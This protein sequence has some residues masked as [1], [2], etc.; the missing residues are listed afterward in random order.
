MVDQQA[1]PQLQRVLAQARKGVIKS[2][3]NDGVPVFVSVS[4]SAVSGW[5]RVLSIAVADVT[6]DLLRSFWLSV[7]V[8]CL[9]LTFG[10]IWARSIG[11]YI[12]LSIVALNDSSLAFVSGHSAEI[13]ISDIAGVSEALLGT[14]RP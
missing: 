5:S 9:L 8:A 4:R 14:S 1:L 13:L 12:S 7:A 3:R 2:V 11:S 10:L 6:A